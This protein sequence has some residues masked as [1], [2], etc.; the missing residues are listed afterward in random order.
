MASVLGTLLKAGQNYF[1]LLPGGCGFRAGYANGQLG[2][3]GSALA[4]PDVEL[5]IQLQHLRP[6][7]AKIIYSYIYHLGTSF[8]DQDPD[9]GVFWIQNR[10]PDPGSLLNVKSP[11]NNFDF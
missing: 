1:Y 5:A 11:Q 4:Y 8:S 2:E 9:S 3:W 6:S 10:N 7:P